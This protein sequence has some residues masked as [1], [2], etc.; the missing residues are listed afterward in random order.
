MGMAVMARGCA[1]RFLS[2]AAG[3]AWIAS[4]AFAVAP[5][6][7]LPTAPPLAMAPGNLSGSAVAPDGSVL[8]QGDFTQVNGIARP[9]LAK[10][11]PDGRLDAAFEP[12]AVAISGPPASQTIVSMGTP[13]SPALLALADGTWVH[14]F[15]SHPLAYRPDGTLDLRYSFLSD[16][17][18]T[19]E[20]LFE[21]D[22]A[23]Y[24]FRNHPDGRRLE[25]YRRGTFER[26]PMNDS[27][28]W[29]RPAVTAV[30][31]AHG[32]LWVLGREE[33][34][35]SEPV[36]WRTPPHVLF[37]VG[38]DGE[39]DP[40]FPPRELPRDRGY[41]ILPRN[42]GGFRFIHWD[43]SWIGFWPS[44]LRHCPTI[45]SYDEHAAQ[46]DAF[47]FCMP[48]GIPL[49]LAEEADGSLLHNVAEVRDGQILHELVRRLP[50]GSPD[51]D[52]R[53][54]LEAPA[55][56]LLPDGRIHHSHVRRILPDGSPDPSWQAPSLVTDPAATALG[57]FADGGILVHRDIPPD[58]PAQH[59][60]MVLDASFQPDPAFQ[61]SPDLP[62]ALS[63][64]L[65]RDRLCALA[66]L[67]G[68]HEFADGTR[69]RILRLRRDGSVDP[70]SPRYVPSDGI[71]FIVPGMEPAYAPYTGTFQVHPLP[72]GDML[73]HYMLPDREV[74]SFVLQ[75]LLP[76]GSPDPDFDF[77]GDRHFAFGVFALSDGT[78]LV[79]NQLFAPNGALRGTLDFPAFGAPMAELPD[80]RLVL[81]RYEADIQQLALWNI[82]TGNDPG[83]RTDFLVGTQIRQVLPLPGG[84]L[85]V[86]GSLNVPGG[87]RRIVRLHADGRLDPTFVAPD[88]S[89]TLPWATGLWNV[90]RG[91]AFV[92]ASFANRA[93]DAGLASLTLADGG[94]AVLVAGDFTHLDAQPRSG[95]ALLSL[96]RL[97]TFRDWRDWLPAE[98]AQ[99]DPAA[100]LEAYASG[101]DPADADRPRGLQP[102]TA[103]ERGYRLLL[104]PDA[105][106]VAVDVEVSDDLRNWRPPLPGEIDGT[107]E[108]GG[109]R[110]DM[111]A[112]SPALFMRTRYRIAPG[113]VSVPQ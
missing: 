59:P 35:G 99:D 100:L 98:N 23:L 55:L 7:L 66:I 10:L 18:G 113:E 34:Y 105:A 94:D 32:G 103:G 81:R 73:A 88:V 44:S 58:G 4:A 83:F 33:S 38:A 63:Y 39:L 40:A 17:S 26:L 74:S 87:F 60:L 9:G 2:A 67:R 24:L 62:P 20:I 101:A 30:P 27:G 108:C 90:V 48:F 97:D 53:V 45:E 102:A 21:T 80:G 22:A 65:T 42:G 79:R 5:G 75:R 76:D 28:S 61:P 111:D 72:G 37:R 3:G 6:H 96:R 84:G 16:C 49:L 95:L 91:G 1:A 11:L 70:D 14:S 64:Q 15:P 57:T 107:E 13:D 92:S 89:R 47:S 54:A 109:L 106:D 36:L 25:A 50:D 41:R 85:L 78:F 69:T 43:E 82:E 110:L 71:V 56:S 8:L 68:I 52:F 19:G 31:A 93:R 77:A 46:V 86:E 112:T 104:N 29:P 12:E 51:P